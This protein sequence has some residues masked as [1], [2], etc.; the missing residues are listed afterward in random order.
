MKLGIIGGMGPLAGYDF[1]LRLTK[2]LPSTRDQDHIETVLLSDT[3]IP[4]RTEYILGNSSNDPRIKLIQDVKI[5]NSLK[6]DNIAIICNTA[7]FF[8]DDLASISEAN[9]YN[10]VKISMASL[11]GKKVG[12]M[13]TEGTSLSGIYDNCAEELGVNLVKLDN[14]FQR[15][16]SAIIYN[17]V[18][19]NV[20]VNKEDF[21]SAS[22]YLFSKR[23][24]SVILGCTELS[25]V[26]EKLIPTDRRFIDPI[27]ELIKV[28]Y[29]EST[30]QK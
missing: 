1:G 5:L 17:Q 13:S 4:D 9:I 22:S 28:I 21:F 14:Q 25:T 12:L 15:K 24:D 20:E 6:V 10:I 19:R 29:K 8:Y 30:G 3:K 16:I 2:A 26:V 23:C 18:K 11:R 7:H 27:D